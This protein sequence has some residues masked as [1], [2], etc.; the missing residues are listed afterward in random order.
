MILDELY[1]SEVNFQ[2]ATDWDAG[3]TVAL[4]NDY[5]GFVAKT[6]VAT[7]DE[8]CEWLRSA[9]IKHYPDSA[10]ARAHEGTVAGNLRTILGR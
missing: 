1:A 2:I 3:W 5:S 7:F 4:G 9:A 10:F 8:A 6:N